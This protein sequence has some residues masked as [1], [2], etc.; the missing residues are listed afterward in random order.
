MSLLDRIRPKWQHSDPEVRAAAVRDLGKSDQE[1]LSTVAREDDDPRVRR[2]AV[3]KLE[4]PEILFEVARRDTEA[5]LRELAAERAA[6]LLAN[7]AVSNA[8]VEACA[9][10]LA[11]LDDPKH[12]ATAALNAAHPSIRR[13]A[14]SRVTDEKALGDIARTTRDTSIGRE[15]L[16]R[17]HEVAVLRRVAVGEGLAALVFDALEKIHDPETLDGIAEDRAASKHVRQRAQAK[18]DQLIGDDHPIRDRQRRERQAELCH[19]IEALVGTPN[20]EEAAGHTRDVQNEWEALAAYTEPAEQLRQRFV[21]ACELILTEAA[22]RE[23]LRADEERLQ[24]NLSAA[25]RLCTQVEALEGE[26]APQELRTA[27]AAWHSLAPLPEEYADDLAERF[28]QACRECEQRYDRWQ[29]QAA[30]RSKL[31]ALVMQAERL[32]Q[33]EEL[34]EALERWATLERR[35]TGTTSHARTPTEA[36]E[37]LRERF[38]R[39]G[40]R[41]RARIKDAEACLDEQKQKNLKE[42][43]A[44]CT[45]LEALATADELDLRDADREL[46]A[47]RQLGRIRPLPASESRKAWAG[48]LEAA[49]QELYQRFQAQRDAERWKRWANVDVQEKLIRE[50]ET[51]LATN[52]LRKAV[53][54]I[55]R[56]QE[57]WKRFGTTPRGQSEALWMRFRAARDELHHRCNAYLAD[58]VKRK[59]TLCQQVEG[60]ADSTDWNKTEDEIKSLQATWKE[61]GPVPQRV[62]Q[63]LWERFRRPCDRFFERRNQ[64]LAQLKAERQHNAEMKRELCA[65]VEALADSTDWENAAREIKALQAKWKQVGPVGRKQSDALWERFRKACDHFFGRRKRRAE[66]EREQQL[67]RAATVCETLESLASACEGSDVPPAEMLEQIKSC[68]TEWSSVGNV[69]AEQADA[70]QGRFCSACERIAAA[71]PGSLRGTMLDPETTGK[72]REKLC[73]RLEELVAAV[74]QPPKEESLQDLAAKLKQAWAA[75]T[76]GGAPEKKQDWKA[77]AQDVQRL[78]LAWDRLGPVIG[79]AARG[80]ADR[81]EKAY[82]TFFEQRSTSP[83]TG[84]PR[85]TRPPSS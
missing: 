19:A 76:I 31:E 7:V 72:R 11:R 4:D 5:G 63:A 75:N 16:S 30:F 26:S 17:I 24:A 32:A 33:S 68:V 14:L 67:E 39:A 43:E 38:V 9:N 42:L 61:I 77:A 49:R 28:S 55:R 3:K 15:A 84:R 36:E 74:T 13:L 2:L 81:F 40:D 48:R 64:H 35:W 22:R 71:H 50:L 47:V 65:Q 8:T 52:D 79:E 44:W 57:D 66:I 59:E 20:L 34:L 37:T 62:S 60:L 70:L 58:N 80:C 10:A 83:P 73:V 69:R 27:R 85:A 25:Q 46:R 56:I 51:L 54:D 18:L 45:R 21:E 29:R 53:K 23:R 12:L 78:K 82:A 1:A 41:L 6:S